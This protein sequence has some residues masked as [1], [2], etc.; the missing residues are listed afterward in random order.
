LTRL[1]PHLDCEDV[2]LTG[3]V[4]IALR[5]AARGLRRQ[6]QAVGD[7]DFVTRRFEAV[8]PGVTAEFLVSHFH[9]PQ[10]E[11]PKFLIQLADPVSRL[12]IDIFPDLVG[13]IRRAAVCEIAGAQVRVLDPD[14]ILDHKLATLAMASTL[15]PVDEKHYRDAVLLGNVCGR[16]IP[17]VPSAHLC[18]EDYS[19]DLAARC[20]RCDAS[21]DA[22]FLLAPKQRIFDVLGYV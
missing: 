7:L 14:S 16:E 2:A 6:Q 1:L 15:R 11:Y 10:P 18:N 8:R 19:H 17:S 21:L 4:A 13:S 22:A 12:R 20:P 3:G 5:L 9:Q